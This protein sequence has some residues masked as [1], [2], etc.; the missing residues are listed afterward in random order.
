M[1]APTASPGLAK[2]TRWQLERLLFLL[3]KGG[4]RVLPHAAALGVG[5]A[6]G[7][8]WRSIDRGHVRVAHDNLRHAL[9]DLDDAAREVIVRACFCHFA[10][11]IVDMVSAARF[12]RAEALA[13]ST[14]VGWEHL[15]DAES[16]GCGVL[17]ITAHLGNWESTGPILAL[18]GHP[19]TFIARP[20]DN[21]WLEREIRAIRERFGNQTVAKRG[22]SREILRALRDGGRLAILMDQRVHPMEGKAFP[23]FGRP[24]FTTPLPA[25][26]SLSTGAPVVPFFGRWT[27]EGGYAMRILPPIRPGARTPE[28]IDQLTRQ[29]LEVLEAE[30]RKTPSEWLWIHRRWRE[31]PTLRDRKR[32]PRTAAGSGQPRADT[33]SLFRTA[34]AAGTSAPDDPAR[35]S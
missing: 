32:T 30:I 2:R 35:D 11:L 33:D 21:P 16:D 13:R 9:P 15:E 34:E 7:D 24:A 10:R 23:F 29:Y 17:M 19:V 20:L 26:L 1:E 5:S 27:E 3:I 12:S 18:S 6:L 22:S 31:N 14:A 25:R 28:A 4:F 8:L